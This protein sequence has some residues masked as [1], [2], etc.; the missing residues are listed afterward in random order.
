MFV[1]HVSDEVADGAETVFIGVEHVDLVGRASGTIDVLLVG[2]EDAPL[3]L[4]GL[5]E[6]RT[7][8]FWDLNEEALVLEC[9]FVATTGRQVFVVIGLREQ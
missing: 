2:V 5:Q 8:V 6:V 1:F 4:K 7:N 9:R 3:S